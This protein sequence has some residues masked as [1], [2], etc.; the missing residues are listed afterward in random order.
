[1]DIQKYYLLILIKVGRENVAQV[2]GHNGFPNTLFQ[3]QSDL[4]ARDGMK[5][6]KHWE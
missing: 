4:L 5:Q 1:M 3:N 6:T 2:Q